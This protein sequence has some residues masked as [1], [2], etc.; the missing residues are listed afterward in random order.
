MQSLKAPMQGCNMVQCDAGAT[1]IVGNISLSMWRSRTRDEFDTI[2][3]TS[4]AAKN[5]QLWPEM[6]CEILW[7]LVIPSIRSSSWNF[8]LFVFYFCTSP[9]V[10]TEFHWQ[11]ATM[12]E[13]AGWSESAPRGQDSAQQSK[14]GKTTPSD[15]EFQT[16][17]LG[18]N[19]VA[20]NINT[21]N[22]RRTKHGKCARAST[23]GP[24]LILITTHMLSMP[25]SVCL[26]L[27]DLLV[28][29]IRNSLRSDVMHNWQRLG[30]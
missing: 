23:K 28:P 8:K 30:V 11:V 27:T 1:T 17:L 24:N 9:T 14:T 3:K 25:C 20:K 18:C 13:V 15:A 22:L 29:W 26:C 2:S 12:A 4:F 5:L 10:F 19:K 7:I 16:G 21:K 6:Q